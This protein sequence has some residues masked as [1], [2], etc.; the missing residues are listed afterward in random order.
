MSVG[1][2]PV[3]ATSRSCSAH[4]DSADRR[5]VR[6]DQQLFAQHGIRECPARWISIKRRARE[7]VDVRAA[8]SKPRFAALTK[9]VVHV[10]QQ[11]AAGAARELGEEVDLAPLVPIDAQV[12]RGILDRQ[13]AT[14]GVLGGRHVRADA[15]EGLR[16]PRERAAGPDGYAPRHVDHAR[17]SE[18]M[19][20]SMRS[21]KARRR[22]RSPASGGASA[23]SES[24]TPC[25]LT[26][27]RSRIA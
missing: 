21:A 7:G 5:V 24:E 15:R 9:H 2:G 25:R 11:P 18:T 13:P 17:C 3:R 22:R 26:G 1:R 8:R 19:K 14:E 23:A 6:V 4:T 20:G 12:V 10:E 27:C 16:S